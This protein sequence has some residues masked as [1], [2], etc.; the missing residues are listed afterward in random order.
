MKRFTVWF[1]IVCFGLA[2]R[3]AGAAGADEISVVFENKT[4]DA[5]QKQIDGVL[6]LEMP[7][8]FDALGVKYS[9]D[10]AQPDQ[11]RA[12]Y[13]DRE[14]LLTAGASAAV[15]D[16]V[17]IELDARILRQNGQIYVPLP[18]LVYGFNMIQSADDKGRIV[19][20]NKP[21]RPDA[22]KEY[23]EEMETALAG[24]PEGKQL[25]A[26]DAIFSA[27]H[28]G[29][30]G[31][32]AREVAITDEAFSKALEVETL[33][34][35]PNEYDLQIE[36][37]TVEDYTAKEFGMISFYA[38][39]ISTTDESDKAF[40]GVILEQDFGASNK[41]AMTEVVLDSNWEKFFVPISSS[42]ITCN[43]GESKFAFRVA[44]QPQVIQIADVQVVNYGRGIS[45]AM[46]PKRPSSYRG[47]EEDAIWRTEA[48]KRIEK[49]RMNDLTV[50]VRNAD[51]SP[52]PGAE[53]RAEMTRSEFLFGTAVLPQQMK[54]NGK[55]I[56][57]LKRY[58]N[59]VVPDS[60]QKWPA[61]EPN[62]GENT[63][64]I[65]NWAAENNMYIRGHNL[66]WDGV[67]HLP[68]DLAAGF[69]EMTDSQLRT[70]ID[71]HI[72]EVATYTKGL[73]VQWDVLNEPIKNVDIRSRLG[74]SEAARWFNLTAAVDPST[75]RYLNE[76]HLTGDRTNPNEAKLY[77]IVKTALENGA[78]IDGVGLQCHCAGEAVYPQGIYNQLDLFAQM[79]DE[80]AITEYD[81][82]SA[83]A[84]DEANQLRDYLIAVY[85][86][87]QATA[88]MMWEFW[89]GCHWKKQAPLFYD[90]WSPK[91]ALAEWERLVCGEWF[92]KET[93]RTDA[94]GKAVIRGHRGEYLVS[95]TAGGKKASVPFRL[96]KEGENTVT[97]TV[98]DTIEM[99]P[100][101]EVV[102]EA[103]RE[104][105]PRN[106]GQLTEIEPIPPAAPATQP[107]LVRTFTND[108]ISAEQ[109]LDGLDATFWAAKGESPWI[110]YEY[111]H[112][113]SFDAVE[114]DWYNGA[115]A[116]YRCRIECSDDGE[117]WTPV[118][119][120]ISRQKTER[121]SLNGATG[122]Y[123]RICGVNNL[124]YT[125][126]SE[127]R[128]ALSEA[129][130]MLGGTYEE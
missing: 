59:A 31:F 60:D 42:S 100:S 67:T 12:F 109:T 115:A 87:P 21:Q 112:P 24:F 15:V 27:H 74:E 102:Q 45:A 66:F 7:A 110:A 22:V 30:E 104:V 75:K 126:I 80:V 71:N 107:K 14:M 73:Q 13:N 91:P 79:V 44:Y 28:K 35:Y 116:R 70:R 57:R 98:G 96:V 77:E 40:L 23:A 36:M 52:V 78:K 64:Y 128:I 89:D 20:E 38:R 61:I 47:V 54:T 125:A 9:V 6:Y 55:Y 118:N 53:V 94:D 19:L 83:N 8:F 93:A 63:A 130:G 119:E 122:K 41:A 95:V 68:G 43:A 92:T 56:A 4:V 101:N 37:G 58:F 39:K 62:K 86:H 84:A 50:T 10:P 25:V 34:K 72:N 120:E 2:C 97:V 49:Y 106:F 88:F 76:T 51:G 16:D 129:P 69:E 123:L 113:V 111:D 114:I 124:G 5:Q 108:G 3:P 26:A 32:T 29:E 117:H 48:E 65:Y 103:K 1:V 99:I 18:F 81:F 121:V 82:L 127:V 17:T 90:D 33:K 105:D 85:S 11:V 46:L